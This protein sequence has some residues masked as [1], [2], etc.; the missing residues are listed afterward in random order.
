MIRGGEQS[1]RKHRRDT[2]FQ[3]LQEIQACW[4]EGLGDE[5]MLPDGLEAVRLVTLV[6]EV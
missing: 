1:N 4:V 3:C 2:G 6:L 5:Q